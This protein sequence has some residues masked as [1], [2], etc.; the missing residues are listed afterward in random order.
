M[1]NLLDPSFGSHFFFRCW[2]PEIAFFVNFQYLLIFQK[3]PFLSFFWSVSWDLTAFFP[4]LKIIFLEK[5]LF[6]L[7]KDFF[8]INSTYGKKNQAKEWTKTRWGTHKVFG[9][10][11]RPCGC[12]LNAHCCVFPLSVQPSRETVMESVSCQLFRVNVRRISLPLPCPVHL[13]V[14]PRVTRHWIFGPT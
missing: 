10:H 6:P 3:K 13:C 2:A 5:I 14:P 11:P 8:S 4:P 9:N 7:S 12:A 1:C